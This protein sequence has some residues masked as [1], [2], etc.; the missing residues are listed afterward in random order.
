MTL[1]RIS[2]FNMAHSYKKK[3]LV[4]L[5]RKRCL[6]IGYM[7]AEIRSTQASPVLLINLSG[8]F[9][10]RTPSGL[11]FT[12]TLLLPAGATAELVAHNSLIADLMLDQL[13]GDFERV[14]RAMSALYSGT[15]INLKNESAIV[16]LMQDIYDHEY[17]LGITI[18]KL[19]SYFCTLTPLEEKPVFDP[20]IEKIV[21]RICAQPFDPQTVA[22]FAAQSNLSVPRLVELFKREMGVPI[23]KYRIWRRFFSAAEN[24]AT[25]GNI[26]EAA[27]AAGFCDSSHYSRRFKDTFGV[28]PRYI[29]G[30]D[31]NIIVKTEEPALSP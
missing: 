16:A 15:Y 21:A 3:Q 29:F 13:S 19:R 31:T 27:H 23:S 8:R 10:I 25:T 24:I 7:P 2:A 1:L 9:E 11:V 26:T 4:Y 20:R 22:D 30:P 17:D 5:A 18:H 12:R 14:K 28:S 6:F